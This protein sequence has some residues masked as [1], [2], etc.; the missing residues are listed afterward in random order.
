MTRKETHQH[1]PNPLITIGFCLASASTVLSAGCASS[2]STSSAAKGNV[3]VITLPNE[4]ER[5]AAA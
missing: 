5:I 2:G 3:T 1:I 4:G